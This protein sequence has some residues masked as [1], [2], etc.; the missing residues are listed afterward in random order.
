MS[1]L[2]DLRGLVRFSLGLPAFVRHPITA[3]QAREAVRRGL[4]RRPAALL[5]K[6]ERAVF[7]NP[8]SPYRWLLRRA[9]AEAGDVERLVRAE[10]V[11]GALERLRDAGVYVTFEE[12]KG[13]RPIR[14]GSDT[15]TARE[16]DFDNPCITAHYRGSS[17][18]ASGPPTRIV[19]D[20]EHL[21]ETAPH[22]RLWF[23][24]HGWMGRPLALWTE[25]G[26]MVANRHLLCT[27]FGQRFDRWFCYT[28]PRGLKARL[29]AGWVHALVRRAAAIPAPEM[30]RVDQAGRVAEYLLAHRGQGR[31]PC[32]ITTPSQAIHIGLAAR[33][34]GQTLDGVSFLVGG[35]PLTPT[36]RRTIEADGARAVP[37]YGFAEGGNV[38]SQCGQPPAVDDIHV[39]LDAYAVV[40]RP[41]PVAEAVTVDALLLTALR[42]SCPKVL[43]NT[44][45]GDS[46]VVTWRDCRCLF[47]RLGY[48][49]HL[50]TIRSFDKL[51]GVGLTF[52]GADLYQV[53]EEV[54]P[55]RF[56]GSALDYQVVEQQDPRGLPRYRLLVSP[57]IGPVDE[58]RLSQTF[59]A[60]LARRWS[61][62]RWMTEVW[63]R[64]GV[65]EVRR[66]RPVATPTGKVFPF[67][68]LGPE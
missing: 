46:A 31:W 19:V 49:Q 27:R 18:G 50:H 2:N 60:E 8:R 41:R 5:E 38:G 17:G 14:R 65:L 16:A 61:A 44:E 25:G 10:G 28:R 1:L 67:R 57:E 55:A 68:T 56:G 59:L 37:T 24:E 39:S 11:E 53:M 48:R 6:V 35:E 26:A 9:G 54:L 13:R 47:G 21:A 66:Q 64:A 45:V 63:S 4:E 32:L 36:R 15:H 51:T 7:G 52:L 23:D 29:A 62:Y 33:D 40:T 3:E 34:R 42:P 43:L 58:Q 20:L 22:H 30:V 12:F